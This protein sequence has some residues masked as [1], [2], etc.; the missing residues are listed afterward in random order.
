MLYAVQ[1]R[2]QSTPS[3]PYPW[4][5]RRT[6]FLDQMN[7]VAIDAQVLHEQWAAEA[8]IGMEETLVEHI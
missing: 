7:P 5:H 6:V 2:H 1:S 3:T 4:V 8:L